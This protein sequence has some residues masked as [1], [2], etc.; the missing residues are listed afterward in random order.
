MKMMTKKKLRYRNIWKEKSGETL[1]EVVVS[2]FLFLMMIGIMQGAVSY[3][4]AALEENKKIRQENAQIIENLQKASQ[5]DAKNQQTS[6]DLPF[7]AVNADFTQMG[8][9]SKFTIPIQLK[10]V[11][12]DYKDKNGNDETTQVCLYGTNDLSTGTGGS[13]P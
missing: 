4:R 9:T 7:S 10:T 2:I 12:V 3:S 8:T 6:K 1:V 13:T 5:D 11:T